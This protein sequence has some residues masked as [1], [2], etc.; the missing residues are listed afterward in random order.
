MPKDLFTVNVLLLI[1]VLATFSIAQEP[2]APTAALAPS[3]PQL[4]VPRLIRFSG[5][6]MAQDARTVGITFAL[7]KDQEGGA[8]LWQEMQNVAIDAT[9]RYSVLLGATSKDGVP[10]ELFTANEARWLGVQVEQ[11]AELPRVL[12]VSVPY[13]LKA[14]DA[15]TVGG[16]PLTD[17]VLT[18][19]SN[20]S[21][22]TSSGSSGGTSGSSTTV[23]KSSTSPAVSSAPVTTAG[24][25]LNFLAKFDATGAN[26]VN[27]L[28]FDNGLVG[29]NNTSPAAQ[30][31]VVAP[32]TGVRSA[33]FAGNSTGL[34][35]NLQIGNTFSGGNA[36]DIGEMFVP[37]TLSIRNVSTAPFYNVMN[38]TAS[39]KLGV[40]TVAPSSRFDV[41]GL[42]ISGTRLVRFAGNATGLNETVELANTASGGNTW[43]IGE[44]FVPGT[45]SI[46]NVSTPPYAA[47]S[48]DPSG[49]VAISGNLTATSISEISSR[50][51]KT[52][53]EPLVGALDRIERLRGVSY[54]FISNR[55]HDIGF[56]AEEAA[57]VVPEVVLRGEDGEAKSINYGRLTALLVEAVKEQQAQIRS[58]QSEIRSLKA[59]PRDSGRRA[60][61][62]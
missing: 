52:N 57:Q 35:E 34:N 33:I 47:V 30:L 45:L 17:F 56:I 26:L 44:I 49:S 37:G 42:G 1:V 2:A 62:K 19:P 59:K 41:V 40:G 55:K 13:A 61:A 24:G 27:S 7:Y 31:H 8:P 29:I 48:I 38:M 6:M 10:T 14:G 23:K 36:W 20:A 43:E 16:H 32:G 46:R 60:S 28:L 50:R 21:S 58:L 22:T 3:A 4:Q 12:L 15:E 54:D 39:G 25:T 11:E 51:W 5:A 18:S 9:G 53:I